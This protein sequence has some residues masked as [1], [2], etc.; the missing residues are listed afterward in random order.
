[1]TKKF[2]NPPGMKPLGM[3]T[4]VTVATGGSLA[5]TLFGPN[6]AVARWNGATWSA[7]G[8]LPLS[9]VNALRTYDDAQ[10]LEGLDDGAV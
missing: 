6:T 8:S 7:V 9:G 3:Y 10:H 4:Q 5:F 2:V 1:M